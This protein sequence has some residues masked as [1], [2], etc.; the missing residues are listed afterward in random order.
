MACKPNAAVT[1]KSVT[2]HLANDNKHGTDFNDQKHY[3]GNVLC[4]SSYESTEL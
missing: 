4:L 3:L 1:P 2:A